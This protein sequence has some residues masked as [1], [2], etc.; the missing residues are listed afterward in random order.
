MVEK[1]VIVIGLPGS[2]KTTFLAALWHVISAREIPTALRFDTLAVGEQTHLNRI[3]ARWRDAI[4]Q[5]R[6]ES[7]GAKLVGIN[8]L[9]AADSAG[10]GDGRRCCRIVI[11]ATTVLSLEHCCSDYR[12]Q[13]SPMACPINWAPTLGSK[14]LNSP[15]TIT[16]MLSHSSYEPICSAALLDPGHSILGSLPSMAS[17]QPTPRQL[18]TDYPATSGMSW[19]RACRWRLGGATGTSAPEFGQRSWT[20]SFG[21]HSPPSVSFTSPQTIICSWLWRTPPPVAIE[22]GIF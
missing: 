20:F 16:W 9:N 11:L 19:R 3:A 17:K 15:T 22:G 21:A 18:R 6:T 5:D 2:G 1:S 14:R 12:V 4:V 10:R 13:S 7:G 8:L